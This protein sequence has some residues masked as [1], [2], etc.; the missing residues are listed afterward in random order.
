MLQGKLPV[1]TMLCVTLFLPS[2]K[3][4][5]GTDE[6]AQIAPLSSETDSSDNVE[7]PSFDIYNN[8][9]NSMDIYNSVVHK[10]PAY[11]K[12][13]NG[14]RYIGLSIS[15][16][17]EFGCYTLSDEEVRNLKKGDELKVDN[18]LTVV[19]ENIMEF[20]NWEDPNY[21]SSGINLG[22]GIESRQKGLITLNNYQFLVHPKAEKRLS[23]NERHECNA[24]P[25]HWLLCQSKYNRYNAASGIGSPVRI[26]SERWVPVDNICPFKV[27]KLT[28]NGEY[29]VICEGEYKDLCG[30]LNKY[31]PVSRENC[32]AIITMND[33]K[34]AIAE[35]LIITGF[36]DLKNES[37][38]A[39]Y[40]SDEGNIDISDSMVYRDPAYYKEENGVKYIGL[41]GSYSEEDRCYAL[42]DEDVRNLKIGDEIKVDNAQTVHVKTVKEFPDWEDPSAPPEGEMMGTGKTSRPKGL[43]A[44]NNTYYLVHPKTEIKIDG[45]VWHECNADSSLWLLCESRFNAASGF[46]EPIKIHTDRWI[47]VD[48][49]FKF[50]ICS[51]TNSGDYDDKCEGEFKDLYDSLMQYAPKDAVAYKAW[52]T[53]NES[54]TAITEMRIII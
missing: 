5:D 49:S 50:I 48:N 27:C 1:I 53:M 18:V 31:L 21:P 16:F 3:T 37:S 9:E 20:P 51:L 30:S 39:D 34:T 52:V 19:V 10:D 25:D 35:I 6:S 4:N 42:S 23:G 32:D 12:A 40:N 29:E 26:H 14:V 17:E 36:R 28:Y 38:F 15:Y 11:Y 45:T 8:D 13:E 54:K 24:D 46:G 7:H 2:C 43:I 47:P 33:S 41:A 22:N 44:L